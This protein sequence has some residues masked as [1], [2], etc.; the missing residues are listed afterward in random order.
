MTIRIGLLFIYIVSTE[1]QLY[2]KLWYLI[3]YTLNE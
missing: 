2:M 1:G 3:L